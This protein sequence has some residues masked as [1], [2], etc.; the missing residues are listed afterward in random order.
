MAVSFKFYADSGLLSE[1]TLGQARELSD[2]TTPDTENDQIAYFGSTETGKK[3]RA[4]SDPGTDPVNV[5]PAYAVTVWAVSATIAEDDIRMPSNNNGKKYRA[6]GSGT[7]HASTEPTW[8]TT[9]GQTVTDNDFDWECLE[10]LHQPDEITLGLSAA[11][12]DINTPGAALS[13]GT[14]VLSEVANAVPVYIRFDQG[15]HPLG[16]YTD[17]KLQCVQLDEEDV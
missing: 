10:D 17:L 9:D 12:L 3:A 6:L 13:L 11:A 5:T 1:L 7:T 8:P 4:T 16:T 2:G 15:V 14:S